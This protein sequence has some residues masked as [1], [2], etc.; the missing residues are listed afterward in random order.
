LGQS[1]RQASEEE[2]DLD[3]SGRVAIVTGASRGIGEGIAVA[4]ASVGAR[5]LVTHL[6]DPE[7]EGAAKEVVDRI[8]KEGGA[9]RCSALRL[10][11]PASIAECVA[12]CLRQFSRIDILVNNAG[13][14]QR[15]SGLATSDEDFDRCYDVNLKGVWAMSQACIPYL[16]AAGEGRILNISSGAGRRGS[17][18]LPA[19]C[20][21]KAAV[22]S[23]T[24]SLASALASDNITVN[25]ICPGIILSTMSKAFARITSF[26]NRQHGDDVEAMVA[27]SEREIPLGRMQTPADIGHVATFMASALARNIT[28]QALNVDGGVI[29]N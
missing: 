20:A 29:M 23:L 7:D 21:S 3:L 2:A 28:G 4:L 5:V 14:M 9:A 24:Q 11:Y 15:S 17:A 6:P 19:Y 10:P 12:E 25:A 26:P 27:W 13:V 22:I 16:K 18:N 8:E 1:G